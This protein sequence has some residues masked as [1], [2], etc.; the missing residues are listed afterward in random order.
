MSPVRRQDEDH[1]LAH[2]KERQIQTAHLHELRLQVLDDGGRQQKE[3]QMRHPCFN[4][5]NCRYVK[6]TIDTQRPRFYCKKGWFDDCPEELLPHFGSRR[7][8]DFSA[9]GETAC[10]YINA[11]TALP[12]WLTQTIIELTATVIK[13]KMGQGLRVYIPADIVKEFYKERIAQMLDDGMS[14]R[15][16]ARELKVS[17]ATVRKIARKHEIHGG[18]KGGL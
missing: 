15:A 13:P 7:C 9:A 14:I 1:R 18:E 8:P 10:A 2:E 5:I 16:I 12:D 4:C 11:K 6:G 3:N 17:R